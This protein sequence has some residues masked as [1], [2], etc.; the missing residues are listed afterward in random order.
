MQP[1][2]PDEEVARERAHE[3]APHPSEH[4]SVAEREDVIRH[5]HEHP[6]D[7][8]PPRRRGWRFW[9]RD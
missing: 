8:D 5:E 7:E 2:G 9:R 6:P 3:L 1:T 4:D